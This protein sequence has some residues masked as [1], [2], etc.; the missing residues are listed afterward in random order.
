MASTATRFKVASGVFS[1]VRRISVRVRRPRSDSV[2]AVGTWEEW[3]LGGLSLPGARR[4]VPTG[5]DLIGSG[6]FLIAG[7]L[8]KPLVAIRDIP[9]QPR[10]DQVGNRYKHSV[11]VKDGKREEKEKANMAGIPAVINFQYISPKLKDPPHVEGQWIYH[12]E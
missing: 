11:R 9:K 4:S 12:G 6:E 5:K 10:V 3:R 8:P 2:R 1:T 7:Y